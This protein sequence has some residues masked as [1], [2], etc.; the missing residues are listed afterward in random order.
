MLLGDCLFDRQRGLLTNQVS[1]EQWHLPR[2]ELQVLSLLIDNQNKVVAKQ[3]LGAGDE[4][5]SALS[6][7][8]VTRAVFMLRSFLGPL[9]EQ[10][11]ETVKG[12]GYRLHIDKYVSE[13]NQH[14]RFRELKANYNAMITY[15]FGQHHRVLKAWVGVLVLVLF[16]LVSVQW[17]LAAQAVVHHSAPYSTH[18]ITL[19]SGQ[20]ITF[21]SYA[22]SKTNNTSLV[23]LSSRLARGF[24]Q[25]KTSSWQ[26]VYL[27]LSHDKQVFNITMRGEKLGQS[28]VRN[29]KLTDYRQQKSF[30][31]DRWLTE[32]SLC[33]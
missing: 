7:S 29:L 23:T 13:S 30:V 9:H 24:A 32:V 2:A 4:E 15:L 33:E 18:S 16:V 17:I 28:L 19:D 8:S 26:Q 14:T 6:D 25:C 5:Y 20:K 3:I 10:M 11:I 12:K 22:K 27:S 31:S 1:G 21:I